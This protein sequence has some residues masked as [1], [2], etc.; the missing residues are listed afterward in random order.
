MCTRT[1][2]RIRYIALGLL[3]LLTFAG[4]AS[5]A[6]GQGSSLPSSDVGKFNGP[7]ACAASS[8]H[9]GVQPKNTTR[10]RQNEFSIWAAQDKHS[11]AYSV[12]SN[13]VSLRMGKIL[14][15]P[16]EEPNTSPKCLACHALFVPESSRATTFKV[17]DGVSCENCHGPAAGW[18][19]YHTTKDW[20]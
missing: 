19:G 17:D 14:Q 9:G 13:P 5:V 18:L 6:F 15:P 7:G 1:I 16:I 10:I 3:T 20:Q 8:C 11:R 4:A 12:L 2:P